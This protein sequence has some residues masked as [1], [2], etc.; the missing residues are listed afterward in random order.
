MDE[1]AASI[2]AHYAF[3]PEFAE[4]L[5]QDRGTAAEA[6][7]ELGIHLTDDLWEALEQVSKDELI[8]M[9]ALMKAGAEG[10]NMLAWP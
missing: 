7:A 5:K 10:M 3:K 2:Q 8:R 1:S 6:L 9:Q 4:K